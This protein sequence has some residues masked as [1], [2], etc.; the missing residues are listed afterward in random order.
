MLYKNDLTG[1]IDLAADPHNPED[2][3]RGT[4]AGAPPTLEF[5][6]R[7]SGQRPVSIGG[8]RHNLDAD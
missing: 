2:H 8:W 6:E 1:A 5:F 4:V 7:R 3:I